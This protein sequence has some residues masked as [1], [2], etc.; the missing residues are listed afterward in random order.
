MTNNISLRDDTR[1]VSPVIGFILVFSILVMTFAVYQVEI[2][3]QDNY[4]TEVE[5]NQ[6]L[7]NELLNL[8]D[9][10]HNTG[11]DNISRSVTITPGT[12]YNSRTFARNPL[13]PAGTISTVEFDTNVTIEYEDRDPLNFTTSAIEYEPDYSE[14]H[15]APTTRIEHTLVYNDFEAD[16]AT[17]TRSG[18]RLVEPNRLVIPIVRGDL[19]ESTVDRVSV[20]AVKVDACSVDESGVSVTLPT[21]SPER[22]EEELE[23]FEKENDETVRFN[24]DVSDV[25][26]YMVSVDEVGADPSEESLDCEW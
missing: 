14:Y 12:Q 2:V 4:Q 6:Q 13:P 15:G 21:H 24:G 5:H 8:R 20:Q 3:P 18:P 9:A 23:D 22:L 26:I 10:M 11:Q 19:S 1:A 17:V 25:T 16:D 7:Q